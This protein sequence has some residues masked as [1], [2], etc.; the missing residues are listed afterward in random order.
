MGEQLS[1]GQKTADD[2]L[3]SAKISSF[4]GA[5]DHPLDFYRTNMRI[6]VATLLVGLSLKK[7]LQVA[8][9]ALIWHSFVQ[10]LV[11]GVGN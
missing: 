10:E 8:I 7:Y 11:F 3:G 4:F 6:K 1:D 9:I 5:A 2:E